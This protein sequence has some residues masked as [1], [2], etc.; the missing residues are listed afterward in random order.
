VHPA[1]AG[2]LGGWYSRQSLFDYYSLMTLTTL[3]YGEITPITPPAT[4]LTWMEA[5]FGQFYIAVI[6]AQ[7]VGLRLAEALQPP[8]PDLR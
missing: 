4:S 7:L 5:M 3:G 6:V 2:Q 8:D 1:I